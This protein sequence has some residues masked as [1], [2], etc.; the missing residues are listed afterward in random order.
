MT[1][2][3]DGTPAHLGAAHEIA[4]AV[5]D[6]GLT[7]VEV[8]EHFLAR[9]ERL[10]P[11]LHAFLH[12][13]RALT[14]EAA[15][16]VDAR[17]AAGEA[18]GPLA[19]VPVAL[20]DNMCLRGAP[21]TCASRILEGWR[22]PYDADVVT[23]LL[24]ADAV[25]LG[26]TNL[27]EFAM[28]SSTEWS[29]FGPTRNP[30][31]ETRVPGGSSGGSAAAVA[32]GL[33]PVALG[34][35]T[36]GS[37]RQPA[38]L[39]GVLGMMGTYGRVS[40]RG[41]VAFGSSLDRIGPLTRSAADT[42]LVM[43]VLS[44]GDAGDATSVREPAPDW[45]ASVHGDVRGLRLGVVRGV[46][47]VED[48][49][50]RVCDAAVAALVEA[51]AEVREVT[52]PLIEHA[53]SVYYLV[54]PSE[55]SSNLARYDGVRYG[56]RVHEHDGRALSLADM[57][58]ETREQGFGPE[59]K[60]RILLGTFALSAGYS[61]A[62]YEKA[63]RAR[64]LIADGFAGLFEH[65]DAVVSPTSPFPA[66]PLGARLDD[67][68]AMYLCDL[69]AAPASLAGLPSASLPAGLTEDGLPV[70]LQ[71]S[72]PPLREDVILRVAGALERVRGRPDIPEIYR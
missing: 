50:E 21:T 56:L 49:T 68:V 30:W 67:P 58:M 6:G 12:V 11:R 13:D 72:A 15:H 37:I 34:S 64:R 43:S 59:V 44:G 53:I 35:D 46:K 55:A 20:K 42:A 19:G 14:L 57:Q 38:S 27:D 17:R 7:A 5:R 31:D 52:L 32:A 16:A 66:F 8:A 25:P 22:P 65:V 62:F 54:A 24:A 4:A 40:R 2:L 69:L 71:V 28:G 39:C 47:D 1:A 51:G 60:R 70:G 26:K 23:R 61:Q 63:L 48:E 29:A 41:L 18:L 3:P 10:D 36:G 9:V 33:A 45:G